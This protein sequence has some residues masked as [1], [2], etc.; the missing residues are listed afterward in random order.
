MVVVDKR[1]FEKRDSLCIMP[2]SLKPDQTLKDLRNQWVYDIKFFKEKCKENDIMSKTKNSFEQEVQ[3]L[4]KED[5]QDPYITRRKY[6][7]LMQN[8]N[9]L[10]QKIRDKQEELNEKSVQK[11]VEKAAKIALEVISNKFMY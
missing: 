8:R 1:D 3:N 5:T 10:T 7:I 11:N 9:E 4:L 6:E 2:M